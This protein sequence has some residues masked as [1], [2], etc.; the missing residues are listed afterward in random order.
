LVSRVRA[1]LG[2]DLAIRTLF[3]APTAAGVTARVLDGGVEAPPLRRGERPAIV[4][5][6]FAQQR[7]WFLQR[8]DSA[9]ATYNIPFALRLEGPMDAAALEAA[10]ND[11]VGRHES[12]RTIFPDV[13]GIPRQ[14]ILVRAALPVPRV[15][16]TAG[17]LPQRLTAAASRGFDL[18][19]E[20]PLRAQVY[21]L[22]PE[23]HVLQLVMHHIAS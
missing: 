18:S 19:R 9:S 6:S 14:E 5:L 7:L 11:V 21:R 23:R 13:S 12:L 3:E 4:P 17:Q 20:C 8:L 10:L 16:T 2:V 1:T 15:A 22:G